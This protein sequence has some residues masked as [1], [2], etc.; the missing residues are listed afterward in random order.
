MSKKLKLRKIC[1]PMAWMREDERMA[2]ANKLAVKKFGNIDGDF[3]RVERLGYASGICDAMLTPEDIG[4]ILDLVRE[5]Q[6]NYNATEG[7]YPEVIRRFNAIKFK[8]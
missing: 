6:T 4:T 3:G 5:E 7:C 1:D 2:F 8:K